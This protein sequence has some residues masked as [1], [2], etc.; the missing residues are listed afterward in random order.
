MLGQQRHQYQHQH[1]QFDQKPSDRWSS[2]REERD[3]G[4]NI[5]SPTGRNRPFKGIHMPRNGPWD[6]PQAAIGNTTS[7]GWSSG[8][9]I[10]GVHAPQSVDGV[11]YVYNKVHKEG[12]LALI[13]RGVALKP[14]QAHGPAGQTP[15]PT[16]IAMHGYFP[17]GTQPP[18]QHQ[19]HPSHPT[20][21]SNGGSK[22]SSNGAQQQQ[23]QH[24]M[25]YPSPPAQINEDNKGL[26][27]WKAASSKTATPAIGSVN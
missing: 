3:P 13:C 27:F 8:E 14:I 10:F 25:P 26:D 1:Q 23:L 12:M 4:F 24:Q 6:G 21:Q 20:A 22:R 9:G 18:A 17:Q 19:Q 7:N 2:D 15:F 5:M 11:S 16:L